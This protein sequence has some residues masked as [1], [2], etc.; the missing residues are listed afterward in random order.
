[1]NK[2]VRRYRKISYILG[3]EE[4]ILLKWPYYLKQF[5]DIMYP[6]QITHTA[7]QITRTNNLKTYMQS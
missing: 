3:F 4:L 6:Y 1:M 2:L 7:F 5:A